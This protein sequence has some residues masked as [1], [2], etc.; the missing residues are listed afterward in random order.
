MSRRSN[1]NDSTKTTG[2][3]RRDFIKAS[4]LAA[5]YGVWVAN[6]S[7]VALGQ[8]AANDKVNVAWVGAGGKGA[9]DID[10]VAKIANILAV[11][12]TDSKLGDAKA[13]QLTKNGKG[14]KVYNDWRKL[15]D[16]MG[17]E[18]DAV[19]VSIPDHN[20]AIVAL[21]AMKMGKHIYCQKPL[22]HSIAEARLM[23]ETAAEHKVVTQ[24]GNQGTASAGLRTG[25]EVIQSG[26][27]GKIR[28]VHVWTNR[29]IWPQAPDVMD[30]PKGE[31]T[32]PANINWDVWTGPAP[33]HP[34]SEAYNSFK[35][36]GYW[37]FGPARWA[38]WVA[39]PSTCRSW[40]SR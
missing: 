3:N 19:G 38:T 13:K 4:A 5:G 17:K 2:A 11:C 30:W 22:T 39:T 16:E 14:P 9:G 27:L 29:P 26:M 33:E 21:H 12:D 1:E 35:W 10:Q 7:N 36:R 28:E 6:Q 20:H 8:Q 25:V 37:D 31:S 32:P 15:F 34:F 24:M 18:I 23:R 40:A